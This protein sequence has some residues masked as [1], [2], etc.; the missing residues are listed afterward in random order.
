ML[1]IFFGDREN[2]IEN[3][4]VYFRNTYEE[5]WLLDDFAK[6]VVK[7]VD[8][9]EVIGA[10]SIVSPVL[11]NISPE[12]LSGGVKTLLLMKNKPGKVFNAS[13]CGNNCAKWIL[14]IAEEKNITI[15]LHHV[16]DFGKENFEIK[17]I[18][19]KNGIIVH[20]MEELLDAGALILRRKQ[21]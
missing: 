17:I 15:C 20:N 18:N 10:H 16:M 6:M 5:K 8:K 11:G 21:K 13:N 9:S 2:T 14:K 3:T 12:Y 7:D 4:S 1:K 19:D